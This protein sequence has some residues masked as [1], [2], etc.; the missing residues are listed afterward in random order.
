[1]GKMSFLPVRKP[2]AMVVVA[3]VDVEVIKRL[4]GIGAKGWILG[5]NEGIQRMNDSRD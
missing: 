5:C 4:V 3:I 1:M 2:P